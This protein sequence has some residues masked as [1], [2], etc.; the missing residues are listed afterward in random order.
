MRSPYAGDLIPSLPP[1]LK[2][3]LFAAFDLGILWNKG[4]GQA[5]VTAIITDTT[6]AML[7]EILDPTQPGYHDTAAPV[8][9]QSI[10]VSV[11]PPIAGPTP[12]GDGGTEGK[13]PEGAR[14]A[15]K[16]QRSAPQGC[17]PG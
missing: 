17:A 5:T 15:P 16:R 10:G 14:S 11:Q 12:H 13:R 1:A 7:P 9:S 2:A 3:R 6:L 4:T 8:D